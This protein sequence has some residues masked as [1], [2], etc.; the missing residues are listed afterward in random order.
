MAVGLHVGMKEVE[1]E[2]H[3]EWCEWSDRVALRVCDVRF[4]CVGERRV[5]SAIQQEPARAFIKANNDALIQTYSLTSA[6]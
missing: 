6:S 4:C 3:S 1:G 5:Q 2:V